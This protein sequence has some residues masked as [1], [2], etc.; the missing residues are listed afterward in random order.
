MYK[1]SIFI[2]RRDLRLED[3]TTLLQA[4]SESEK[5]LPIFIFDPRQSDKK[6]NDYFSEHSFQFLIQTLHDL[7]STL[8]KRGSKLSFFRGRPEDVIELLLDDGF[9]AVYFNRDHT[10]FSRRRDKQILDVVEAKG[11]HAHHNWD[12]LLVQPGSVCTKTGEPYKVFSPFRRS[13]MDQKVDRPKKFGY[14]NFYSTLH[15][16]AESTDVLREFMPPEKDLA[17]SAG[18]GHALDILKNIGDYQNY[19]NDRNLP[20]V[21]GTTRLSGHLKFGSVSV[22]EVYWKIVD[23]FGK[24]HK[25]VSELYWRDFYAHL[26]WHYPELLG[27]EMQEKYRGMKWTN[28]SKKLRAWKE[29][30]T[31]YPIVD[32]GMRELNETGWMHNRVRMIV[33]N[34]LTK[35]L[36][37]DWREGEKYFAQ[38]LLDYDPANNNGGWQWA[39]STGADA[40]PYFRIFNPWTQQKKF[41]KDAHYI[42]EYIPELRDVSAKEIHD[43]E[44]RGVPE[45]VDYPEP[46]VDHAEERKV[47]LSL[48]KER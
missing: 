11:C 27:Q 47:A 33:A 21:Y 5:V 10:P 26:L 16:D 7:D 34:F 37:I 2:F 14:S 31:G 36:H 3:N 30:K 45:G 22:R 35:D 48:Y 24:G 44:K 20:A 29:G 28:D 19:G 23:T 9:E 13:A 38:K 41:D 15:S 32:A 4:C 6:K 25:L 12:A 1:K 39:A 8:K 43:I 46:I 18:R 42:K 17:Q 40:L